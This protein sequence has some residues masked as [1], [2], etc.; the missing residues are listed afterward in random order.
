MPVSIH[1]KTEKIDY[2]EGFILLK[3][4]IAMFVIAACL[5]IVV[6]GISSLSRNGRRLF[7]DVKKEISVRNERVTGLIKQ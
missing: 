4:V 3:G 5:M 1:G 7:F 6:T 2:E